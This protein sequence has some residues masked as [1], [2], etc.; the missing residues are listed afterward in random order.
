VELGKNSLG[1]APFGQRGK[2]YVVLA[3]L[4]VL[5]VC[6]YALTKSTEGRPANLFD[7]NGEANVP[8]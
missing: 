5:L 6:V 4:A 1:G 8:A 3:F 7:L 2:P